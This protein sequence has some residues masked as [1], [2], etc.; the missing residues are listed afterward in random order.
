MYSENIGRRDCLTTVSLLSM[1]VVAGCLDSEDDPPEGESSSSDQNGETPEPPDFSIN[2][3]SINPQK[4]VQSHSDVEIQ[5]DIQ[6][7]GGEGQEQISV[8]LAGDSVYNNQVEIEAGDRERVT[9]E[10]V[11]TEEL[12][13]GP[14]HCVAQTDEDSIQEIVYVGPSDEG[15]HMAA[16]ELLRLG[17]EQ[18]LVH[19]VI[20]DY[21]LDLE[22]SSV[23]IFYKNDGIGTFGTGGT[24]VLPMMSMLATIVEN[25]GWWLGEFEFEYEPDDTLPDPAEGT[26]RWRADI[27]WVHE[28]IQDED[29]LSEAVDKAEETIK[30]D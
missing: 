15:T 29:N 8:E 16:F 21:E 4:V 13:V 18:R 3:L 26:G 5:I 23:K 19:L 22:N 12:S 28:V 25:R 1:G 10:S 20:E 24:D 6:N 2:S 30:R 7:R 27:E 11:T 9:V 17:A 14:I